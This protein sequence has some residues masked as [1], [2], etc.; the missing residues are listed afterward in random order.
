[1]LLDHREQVAEQGALVRGQLAGDR[2]GAGRAGAAGG[3]SDA[4]VPA[5]I[6]VADGLAVAGLGPLCAGYACALLRRNRIAS[7]CLARQ[8]P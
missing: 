6:S 3:L 4:S 5:A 8:A 1:V 2:V 7:W